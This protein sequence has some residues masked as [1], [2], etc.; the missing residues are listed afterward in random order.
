MCGRGF[1]CQPS[2]F[3][4]KR[5]ADVGLVEL[6]IVPVFGQGRQNILQC[7]DGRGG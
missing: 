1:T 7:Q 6:G 5:T 3:R 2:L 4:Q